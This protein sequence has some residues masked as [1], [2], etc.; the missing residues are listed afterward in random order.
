MKERR[1]GRERIRRGERGRGIVSDPLPQGTLTQLLDIQEGSDMF[2][3]H[4][5]GRVQ[6]F[7]SQRIN[8]YKEEI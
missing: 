6:S 1:K 2:Q 4:C 3:G 8:T 5:R 7:L